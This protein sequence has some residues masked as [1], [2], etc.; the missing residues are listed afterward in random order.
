M[1]GAAGR[2]HRRHGRGGARL[3]A[4]SA[5]ATGLRLADL[6]DYRVG[7]SEEPALVL[8]YG[9]IGDSE[10]PAA[11]ALLRAALGAITPGAITP[12]PVDPD[13]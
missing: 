4:R 10:I 13:R 8:G 7:V 3:A 9:N 6:A 12:E 1:P 2:R 11:V 5:A